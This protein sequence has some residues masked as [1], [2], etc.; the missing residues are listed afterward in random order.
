[1]YAITDILIAITGFGIGILVGY[2]VDLVID[3]A[4]LVKTP[5]NRVGAWRTLTRPTSPLITH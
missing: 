2:A 3:L 5:H 1:M 4:G